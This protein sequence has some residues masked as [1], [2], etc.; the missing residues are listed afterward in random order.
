MRLVSL[1]LPALLLTAA[2]PV[3]AQTRLAEQCAAFGETQYRKLSPS[4]DRVTALD[5]PPPALERV[6][7]L[8]RPGQA[9][10]EPPPR[11]C[12]SQIR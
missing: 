1:L 8:D 11:A 7:V 3:A 4:I 5:F 12:G 6:E 10:A 2:L 9:A